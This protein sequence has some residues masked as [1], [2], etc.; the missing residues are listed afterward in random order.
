[1]WF[2]PA[3]NIARSVLP[4]KKQ[5][6]F[7]IM[8][9]VLRSSTLFLVCTSLNQFIWTLPCFCISCCLHIIT[10]AWLF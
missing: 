8:L 5:W 10:H 7:F 2:K 4:L 3:L 6:H 1:M 9:E